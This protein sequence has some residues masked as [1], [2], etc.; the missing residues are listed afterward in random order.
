MSFGAASRYTPNEDVGPLHD[1][2]HT[3]AIGVHAGMSAPTC[4]SSAVRSRAR[5]RSN[6]QMSHLPRSSVEALGSP[7]RPV[8]RD[9]NLHYSVARI[10]RDGCCQDARR[11]D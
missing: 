3:T 2:D 9:G 10:Q 7:L 8:W 1:K 4:S 5:R 11:G 6:H